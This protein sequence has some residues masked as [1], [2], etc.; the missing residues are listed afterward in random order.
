MP[1]FLAAILTT[2]VSIHHLQSVDKK[3]IMQL[4]TPMKRGEESFAVREKSVK[5]WGGVG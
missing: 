4:F 1:L 3:K 5:S 2:A